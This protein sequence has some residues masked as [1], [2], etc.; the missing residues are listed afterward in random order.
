MENCGSGNPTENTTLQNAPSIIRNQNWLIV[1]DGI[2]KIKLICVIVISS[3][4]LTSIKM[5]LADLGRK[6][7]KALQSL[8]DATIIDEEVYLSIFNLT[9]VYVINRWILLVI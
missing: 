8:R 5:V 9:C 7:T 2:I 6:I 1:I 4:Q 3:G